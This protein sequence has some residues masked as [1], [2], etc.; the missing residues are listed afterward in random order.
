VATGSQPN[1]FGWPGQDLERVQGLVSLQDLERL[2]E[3][4][5]ELRRA[6][7]VGGGL[8][9]VEL[10]E[11]L[12]SRGV[13]V[14][15]LVREPSYWSNALPLPE[16]QMINRLIRHEGIDLRLET[17]LEEIL[18]DRRGRAV[19]V[20][21][22]G[23]ETLDCQLVGL[24]AGVRP[25]LSAVEESDIPTG[26][27]VQ[28]DWSFRTGVPDVFAGGD[29]A[30]LV[31]EGEGRNVVEA[32]WYT[33]RAHGEVLADVMTGT[34]RTYDQGIYFNSA[35]F[36]DVEWQ[37][38]GRVTPHQQP[39]FVSGEQH[40][41]WEHE[42]GRVGLRLVHACGAFVGLNAMG[43]R[44]RHRVCEAWIAEGRSSDY[45]LDHLQEASFDP[46]LYRRHEPAIRASMKEQL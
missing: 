32:L 33:A 43:L 28:V 23:G 45:V 8:I 4:T 21:T 31:T 41:W 26:R 12:Y 18:G 15:M 10:A 6:V 30:E 24:T 14:T 46:E 20:R 27:G 25:N 3:V 42:S 19:G 16:S 40:L 7:I 37:T 9:G 34:E 5:P 38:Y 35:K 36:L 39:P 13:A 11:M 2:Q 1:R 29:C 17:E 44:Y 22:T